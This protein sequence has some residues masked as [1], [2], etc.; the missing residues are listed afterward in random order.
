[1][2]SGCVWQ[3]LKK[4]IKWHCGDR[5]GKI[6]LS[7]CLIFVTTRKEKQKTEPNPL[8]SGGGSQKESRRTDSREMV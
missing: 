5:F 4:C 7:P 2:N 3:H 8:G 6:F 1:M